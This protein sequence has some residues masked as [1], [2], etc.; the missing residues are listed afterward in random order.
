MDVP[1][2]LGA[3]NNF[4]DILSFFLIYFAQWICMTFFWIFVFLEKN[5]LNYI[6]LS[7]SIKY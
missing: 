4:V 6:E 3:S 5:E 7:Q 2:I 1:Y